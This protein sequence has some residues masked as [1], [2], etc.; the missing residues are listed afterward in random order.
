MAPSLL[1]LPSND[2]QTVFLSLWLDVCSLTTLDVAVSSH[3]SR[4]RWLTVLRCVRSGALDEWGHS[5]SSL[6]WLSRRG[7]RTSRL[8]MKIDTSRVHVCDI[9]RLDTTDL[10]VIGLE[11]CINVTDQ[12]LAELVNRCL[13]LRTISLA[14][15]DKVTDAGI[16]ALSAGCGQLQSINLRDCKKVTDAGISALSV[17]CG[18][19]HSISILGCDKVTDAGISA[20][21]AGCGQLQFID[22]AGCKKVT[23]AGI[24][25]LSAGCGKLQSINLTGCNKVT[26]A[27]VS[28][29]RLTISI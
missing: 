27:L 28:V 13:K 1:S 29:L 15:C 18:K 21:S 4:P 11:S 8:E 12:C 5:L 16:S 24:S 10:V 26:Y 17:G 3:E 25:A 2:L 7:I 22:L 19:L 14:G 6:M 23:D 9:L 20:L